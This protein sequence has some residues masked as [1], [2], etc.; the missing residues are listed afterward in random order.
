[1]RADPGESPS[2]FLAGLLSGFRELLS[3]SSESMPR[4]DG[5]SHRHGVESS[6]ALLSELDQ[7]LLRVRQRVEEL[8]RESHR[9]L[10]TPSAP[11]CDDRPEARDSIYTQILG[12]ILD[13]H[14][15]LHTQLT[16]ESLNAAA[17]NLQALDKKLTV[18][19]EELEAR[20]TRSIIRRVLRECADAVWPVFTELLSRHSV[21][22]PDPSGLAPSASSAQ[23]ERARAYELAEVREAFIDAPPA[24]IVLRMK[25]VVPVWQASYPPQDSAT[26]R[27]VVI[28]GAG[29]GLL[30]DTISACASALRAEKD[31]LSAELHGSLQEHMALLQ[32]SLKV[33]VSSA[34][35]AD[36]LLSATRE[37]CEDFV[38]EVA[39]RYAA[40]VL[41]R[42]LNRW[43]R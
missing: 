34:G 29:F 35:E 10:S 16:E 24:K 42:A 26:W 2:S 4:G 14:E 31:S 25:G 32:R 37:L 12:E 38:P 20:I 1:M 3:S 39:W 22:W 23:I 43:T 28:Q 30:A 17:D 33:G 36:K 27:R 41:E 18:P 9:P 13:L 21:A 40:P 5:A 19:G 8:R 6:G 7:S 15:K 11:I